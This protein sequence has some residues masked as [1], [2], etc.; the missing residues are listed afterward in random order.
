MFTS[1][2]NYGQVFEKKTQFLIKLV[3][4]FGGYGKTK[5]I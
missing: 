4:Y 2:T 1:D 5:L 3:I